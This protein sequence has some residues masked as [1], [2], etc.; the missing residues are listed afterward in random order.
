MCS[1]NRG[2]EVRMSEEMRLEEKVED[3]RSSQA[4]CEPQWCQIRQKYKTIKSELWASGELLAL[5][6]FTGI[7]IVRNWLALRQDLSIIGCIL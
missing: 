6:F 5:G 4:Y 3:L 1:S 2:Q 7:V